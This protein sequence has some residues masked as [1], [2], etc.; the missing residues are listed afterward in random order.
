MLP[1]ASTLAHGVDA[2]FWL[3]VAMAVAISGLVAGLVLVFSI[4]YRRGTD[5]KRGALPKH[6]AHEVEIG[7][8]AATFFVAI[9]VF[10]W[11]AATQTKAFEI[12]KDAMEIHVVA[13]QWMWKIEHPGGQREI[14]ALHV[15]VGV[16]IRLVMTS[17]DVIHSF[18]VPA[19]RMKQ[20]V[21]PGRYVETW[22]KAT[23][24]GTFH[25]FCA[26]YCGTDHSRMTGGVVVMSPEDYAA[27]AAGSAPD[28]TLAEQGRRLFSQ[29]GCT[30]CHGDSAR[31]RA[32][33]LAGIYN[34]PQPMEAGGFKVADEAYLHDSI[35][36]PQQDVR[37]GF[38]PIM[39]SYQG[40]ASEDQIVSLIAYLK[41]PDMEESK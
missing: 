40:I 25:L 32:P 18:F 3:L 11:A 16:P 7:W 41:S 26:E 6:F 17:Q 24:T 31:V 12:P 19:F 13:K 21:L 2:I 10:W 29:L 20:D 14:N 34:K 22:F 27:W 38:K 15:P 5:A 30:G 35:V 28:A 23:E 36:R 9:F 4:K 8:T 33:S 1:E 37:A 39:P